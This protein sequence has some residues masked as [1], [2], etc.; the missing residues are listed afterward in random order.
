MLH[1]V[2]LHWGKFF[3]V[4]FHRS[5][6]DE[7]FIT[8]CSDYFQRGLYNNEVVDVC[9]GATAN[10]LGVNL[11]V[12]QKSQRSVSLSRYDCSRYKAGVNLFLLY[13]P[14]SKRGKNL[15]GHYNCYVN[16]NYF[17]QNKAAIDECIVKQIQ[18]ET[19]VSAVNVSQTSTETPKTDTT[20]ET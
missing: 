11:N 12:V 5:S 3:A 14:P 8:L 15:D 2:T 20:T 19:Q 17:E 9:I 6:S 10:A 4:L 7:E 13:D 1:Y 18:E 16:K